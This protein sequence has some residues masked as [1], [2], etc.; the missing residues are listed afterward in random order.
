MILTADWTGDGVAT[1]LSA[2]QGGEIRQ[3][4]QLPSPDQSLGVYYGVITQYL[5]FKKW[6]DE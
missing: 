3:L 4:K 5:G 6:E 2:A 1:T